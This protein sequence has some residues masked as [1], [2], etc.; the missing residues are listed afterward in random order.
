MPTEIQDNPQQ[1][2]GCLK[3]L[4]IIFITMIVTV[5]ITFWVLTRF[6]FPGQFTPVELSENE[7]VVLDQ[8]LDLFSGWQLSSTGSE[9]P[10]ETLQ[11]EKY[12][13]QD[14]DRRISLSER[15]LNAMLANNTDLAERLAIDL[16]RDLASGKILIPLDPDFPLFGGTTLKLTAGLELAYSNSRPVVIL[17]GVSIMGVPVPNAWLGGIKNVDLVS[18][19]GNAGFWKAFADGVEM[20]KVEDGEL[21]IELKSSNHKLILSWHERVA[22]PLPGPGT[23][24][25]TGKSAPTGPCLNQAGFQGTAQENRMSCAQ[26]GLPYPKGGLYRSRNCLLLRSC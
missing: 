18:E 9:S 23:S 1:R 26:S 5:A 21:V 11:P 4:A 20:V 24:A 2:T 3:T 15:E 12:S 7:Q 25:Q 19:F 22:R 17:K 14:A 6:I 13:E 8:K 16:S 10:G